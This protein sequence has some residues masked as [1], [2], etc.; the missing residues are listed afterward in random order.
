MGRPCA[1]ARRVALAAAVVALGAGLVPRVAHAAPPRLGAQFRYWA[2]NDQND[3]RNPLVYWA[4]GPFHVQLEVWDF[5]RGKDQF[6]PE[7]GMHLRDHRRS[8][9]SVEWRHENSAE[10]I[11]FG[12]EQV[13]SGHWVGKA[14]VAPIVNTDST[15]VVWSAGLDYYWRSW[16]FATVNVVRDP[17]GND[18]W[19]V[20]MRL[21]LASERNDWVQATLVPASKRT[22]GWAADAKVGWLRL[23]VERNSRYDFSTRDNV[24]LTMGVEFE[25][26]KAKK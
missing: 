17:R 7:V 18:L 23:G 11:T 14:S 20:P 12:S 6:R 24:I 15:D 19:A 9:Y 22:I 3:N 4:P 5:V 2:F 8:S 16:N 21:R 13:L 1:A 10:R 26:P 25:V